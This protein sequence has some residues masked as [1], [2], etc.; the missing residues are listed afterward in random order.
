MSIV[1]YESEGM[2]NIV[3]VATF[4]YCPRIQLEEVINNK[5]QSL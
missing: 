1:N 4:R 2:R 3:I 5:P